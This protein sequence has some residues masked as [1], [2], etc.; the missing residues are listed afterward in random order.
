MTYRIA[1]LKRAARDVEALEA[2]MSSRV[3]SAVDELATD[4]RLH[5]SKKL[6]GPTGAYRIRVGDW[7]VIY[8]I[9]DAAKLVTISR[10]GHRSE[11]Y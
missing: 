4:P 1:W 7:R 11:V 2:E 9:D 6:R 8:E 5:G 3:R 10:V